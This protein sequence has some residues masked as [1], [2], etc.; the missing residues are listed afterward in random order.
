MNILN[1]K[2]EFR[3]AILKLRNELDENTIISNSIKISESFFNNFNIKEFTNILLYSNFG[4]E[5][6]TSFF[7]NKLNEN[8]KTI[9][10]PKV[11]NEFQMDFFKV[12][13]LNSFN[14][15]Y[16]NI[17]EPDGNSLNYKDILK[18]TNDLIIIPGSC[19]SKEGYRIGYG[20][21]FYDRF[22]ANNKNL[23][24]IGICHELQLLDELPYDEYDVQLDYIITEKELLSFNSKKEV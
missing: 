15:G 21:G 12:S 1:S 9:F 7:Y 5:V 10:Y 2:S 18:K 16:K 24:K 22:L 6:N 13:D 8:K 19:F 23:T 11:I 17:K 3:K 14:D 20:K 4:S